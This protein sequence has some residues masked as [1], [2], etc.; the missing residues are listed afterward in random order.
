ME[1]FPRGKGPQRPH[2]LAQ[3]GW[4]NVKETDDICIGQLSIA[5]R[6]LNIGDWQYCLA[7]KTNA[8]VPEA[9]AKGIPRAA[10]F[11]TQMSICV[12]VYLCI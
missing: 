8:S 3:V 2:R 7:I 1:R 5:H 10:I 6:Q 9:N 11:K 4:S 12:F